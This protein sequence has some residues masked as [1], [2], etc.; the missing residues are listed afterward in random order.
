MSEEN[1]FPNARLSRVEIESG[2]II[3]ENT[4]SF[5][6]G[7]G[8][9][10]DY[11]IHN[12]NLY[13]I[14]QTSSDLPSIKVINLSSGEL[15]YFEFDRSIQNYNARYEN[16][17]YYKKE[18]G[19]IPFSDSV[20]IWKFDMDSYQSTYVFTIEQVR[21]YSSNPVAMVC[22]ELAN[23]DEVLF[24]QQ[25]MIND[26]LNRRVDTRAYNI[27]QKKFIWA[28]DS[29]DYLRNGSVWPS[30]Y[31][32]GK[33]FF[34]AAAM[35]YCY[36]AE[37]GEIIWQQDV[38]SRVGGD[39]LLGNML[40]EEGRVI[41]HSN[42]GSVCSFDAISGAHQ[43][44]T[45]KWADTINNLLYYKG[46]IYTASGANGRIH[47]LDIKTGQKI[48]NEQSPNLNCYPNAHFGTCYPNLDPETGIMIIDDLYFT[49][50]ID[51]NK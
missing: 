4:N 32:E 34:K 47:S 19:N 11:Y 46:K 5:L 31:K 38:G 51:L 3:W 2:K 39:M 21:D 50:A 7:L 28:H 24:Y 22:Y 18:F 48:W 30:V 35:L 12:N 44:T 10:I 26:N 13:Y 16:S 45:L 29:V 14:S 17:I 36:H 41:V 8:D 15:V 25:R 27:T 33:V 6:L 20:Q 40:V 23:G 42:G 43:W 9:K 37:T 1:A 49:M